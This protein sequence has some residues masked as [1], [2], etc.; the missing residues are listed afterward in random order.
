MTDIDFDKIRT[1]YA[2]PDI[3]SASGVKL[4][5]NGNEY[6][7]CCPFHGEKT[8][9]F[10]VYR[11]P[12]RAWQ[13]HCFGCGI[14]G[15]AID[16]VK[17]RYGVETGEAC[18]II[19]GDE[20]KSPRSTAEYKEATNAYADYEIG[21]PPES[22]PAIIAGKRTPPL[23]NPKR[24]DTKTGKPKLITY[25]PSMVFP[26]TTKAGELIGYVLRVEFD[27]KK[28][29]P[30]IWWTTNR[31]E[32][33][34]GWSHGS[35]PSPRPFYGLQELTDNPD[36]QVLVVE[37]E[38]C[39]DAAVRLMRGKRVVPITWPGGGKALSKVDWKPLKGR[40]IVIWPDNDVEGWR[41]TLGYA[42]PDMSWHKGI[43][44]YA[45]GDGAKTVKVVHV[46]PEAR[47]PGWDIADAEKDDLGQKGVELIIRDR[48]QAWSPERHE[49]WK[50]EEIAKAAP[51]GVE[52]DDSSRGRVE[53]TAKGQ[54]HEPAI[55]GDK[56][57][58][59]PKAG[60]TGDRRKN[61]DARP[62]PDKKPRRGG[63]DEESSGDA[64][65]RPVQ[66]G[67]G[68]DITDESWRSHL[69]M[70]ADGDGL[71]SNS[72]Q[73]F[74]LLLQ[75]EQRFAGIFAW[76]DF[77]KEVYLQ[78]RPPWDVG[79]NGWTVRKMNDPDVTAAA[80]WLEYCGM[81]PKTNDI[82]KVIQRVA[83]HNSYNPVTES[84]SA[85][86]WDGIPRLSGPVDDDA[87][88]PPWLTRYLGAAATTEN[89]AFGRKWMIG[90]VARAFQPGCKM[91]TMLVLEGPQGLKK[92]TALRTLS[93]G[94]VPGVFTDEI[95]DP[96]SK[97]AGLQMQGAFIIEIGELAALGRAEIEQIKAWLTRQVDRFR[98]PYGKIVED[99]P[100]PCIFAGTVNPIGVGYLKD[101]SGG[102]RFWPVECGEIDLAALAKD[103]P[104]LWAEA[105]AAYVDG[106]KW[107]LTEDE[108]IYATIA[109]AQRY[110]E[111][112]Y[113][114]MIDEY[115]YGRATVTLLDIMHTALDIP[116][117]RRNAIVNKRIAAHL[118]TRGWERINEG[119]GRI[120]Y[121]NP[122]KLV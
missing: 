91:D 54:D 89:A 97:D 90:G 18:R 23:L 13:M 8:E 115:I 29:T 74:A 48:I 25:T 67:R 38:K 17:E 118:H 1:D 80:C 42:G 122:V 105:V 4:T 108:Q 57:D 77:A 56:G 84:L 2:L 78:R 7:A 87:D 72:L 65:S 12:D 33:F 117:E 14:H 103:A 46:T 70:K 62:D 59:Q 3:V 113:S 66:V 63:R 68:F 11:R 53:E 101:P 88:I 51:Q 27:G 119:N 116:K 24:I 86:E 5:K 64:V 50:A 58:V 94:V 60:R 73:N 30:G 99:F 85:L 49:A 71:K 16:F 111:D 106:E 114:T 34:E 96:N 37:G 120:Y 40:S 45:Y 76:N 28:I 100:R 41:T 22:A 9:S 82:G 20:K 121:S 36:H 35:M 43:V 75:Y 98:R 109:Q 81:S 6:A 19:T 44:E 52:Q 107:W 47:P 26:Y 55:A 110:E 95:S 31:A 32:K 69:I 93:N 21:M 112:P 102:R 61:G 39:K 10:T 79:G 92:S 104:Q 83:Q 15:D